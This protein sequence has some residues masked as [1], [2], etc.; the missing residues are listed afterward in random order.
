MKSAILASKV[1][2]G[3]SGHGRRHLFLLITLLVL[4]AF[5][6]ADAGIVA[7]YAQKMSGAEIVS[8]AFAFALV[9]LG[10]IVTIWELDR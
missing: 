9:S 7:W 8:A 3:T 5:A 1:V 10:A 4:I 6:L 2:S